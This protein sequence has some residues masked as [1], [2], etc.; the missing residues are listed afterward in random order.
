MHFHTQYNRNVNLALV[1]V[2]RVNTASVCRPK[3]MEQTQKKSSL[4]D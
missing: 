4:E 2:S 1:N 3:I